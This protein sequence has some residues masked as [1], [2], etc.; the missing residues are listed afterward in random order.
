MAIAL[1]LD[2]V[3]GAVAALEQSLDAALADALD[4][5]ARA[6]AHTAAADHEYVNRTGDLQSLTGDVPHTGRFLGDTLTAAVVAAT[7]YGEH[8]ERR[9]PFLQ[10]AWDAN[11][12]RTEHT[13]DEALRRAVE[14]TPGWSSR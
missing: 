11:V 8:V 5:I 9:K 7:E 4:E 12:G 3:D 14:A 6:V 13:A 1:S 2:G 10:P